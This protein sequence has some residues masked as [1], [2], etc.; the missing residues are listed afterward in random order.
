MA[1]QVRASLRGGGKPPLHGRAG[2]GTCN[3]SIQEAP[4]VRLSLMDRTSMAVEL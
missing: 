3:I 4:F 1:H 2:Y